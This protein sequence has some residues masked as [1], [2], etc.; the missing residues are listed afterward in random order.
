MKMI[1]TTVPAMT[2][3]E[4]SDLSF[5]P[6]LFTDYIGQEKVKKM[7]EV[8]VKS[9]KARCTSLDHILFYG[10]PGLGKTT[11]ANIVAN[12]MGA[13]LSV[14]VGGNIEKTGDIAS[15]LCTM[16]AHDILFI[17]EIHRLPKPC[18]EM[19]YSAMEDGFVTLMIG[20]GQQARSLK[21]QLEP[22]TLLGA[23]TELGSISAPLRDR[24][25]LEC[26]MDYYSENELAEIVQSNAK[27]ME[28][29]LL[30]DNALMIAKA[31]R[32]TPRIAIRL[33]K[34]VRDYAYAENCGNIDKNVIEKTFKLH[35]IKEDGIDETDM[36]IFRALAKG[37]VLGLTTLA[38]II[39]ED[40]GTIEK[41]KEP[42]LLRKQYIEKTPRGRVL[43]E[44][45]YAY[46]ESNNKKN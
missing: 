30:F 11:I 8:A 16:K 39:G 25:S 38:H 17:D 13:E 26:K 31:S 42:F 9:A 6:G 7:V 44:K 3:K 43:T 35:G 28:Y 45:G 29:D 19:L 46:L 12:E 32:E 27:K 10:P 22:F 41:A 37:N 23:T 36:E 33:L 5:R 2:D 1:N 21:M 40:V 24:F 18:E 20:E 34:Q 15:I 4:P 14:L